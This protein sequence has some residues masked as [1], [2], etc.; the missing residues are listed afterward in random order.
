MVQG[1]LI[2]KDGGMYIG[3]FKNGKMHGKG[4]LKTPEYEIEGDF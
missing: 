2:Y 3:G 1:E 4:S